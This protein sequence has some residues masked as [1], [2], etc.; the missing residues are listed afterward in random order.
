M[1]H[2]VS[3]VKELGFSLKSNQKPPLNKE[4]TKVI[5]DFRKVASTVLGIDWIMLGPKA[6]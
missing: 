2:F 5:L 6:G 1:C 4:E 3:C